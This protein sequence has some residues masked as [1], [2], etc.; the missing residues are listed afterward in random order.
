MSQHVSYNFENHPAV[1]TEYVKFLATNSGS[2][3]V[4]KLVEQVEMMKS[5]VSTATDEAKKAV[6]KANPA[7]NK[8]A[9]LVR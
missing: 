4:T 3:K 9:E 1:S 7:S 5:K 8:N 6:S 2:D